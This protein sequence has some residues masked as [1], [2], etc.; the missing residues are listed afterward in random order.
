M[1]KQTKLNFNNVLSKTE[2]KVFFG[3]TLAAGII[4]GITATCIGRALLG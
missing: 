2:A 1:P 3:A 4:L